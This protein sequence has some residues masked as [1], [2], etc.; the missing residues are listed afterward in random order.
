MT[1]VQA[2]GRANILRRNQ[3]DDE[4][5]FGYITKTSCASGLYCRERTATSLVES[6]EP[7]CVRDQRKVQT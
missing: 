3:N 4:R 2:T 1:A 7:S 5:L 6:I